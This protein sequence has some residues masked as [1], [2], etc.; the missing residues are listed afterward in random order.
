MTAPLTERQHEILLAYW[1]H[2]TSRATGEA[3][4][5]HERTVDETL[6]AIR[7]K[8]GVTRSRDLLAAAQKAGLVTLTSRGA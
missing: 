3:L 6:R 5:I 7:R 2:G 8:L 1:K 4:G